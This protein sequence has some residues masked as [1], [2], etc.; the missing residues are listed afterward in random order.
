MPAAPGGIESVSQSLGGAPAKGSGVRESLGES[1]E[2]V[3]EIVGESAPADVTTGGDAGAAPGKGG[4][5][6]LFSDSV[7]GVLGRRKVEEVVVIPPVEEQIAQITSEL[8]RQIEKLQIKVK[9]V[10]GRGEYKAH[11]I[12][13]LYRQI[14]HYRQLITEAVHMAKEAL[15]GLYRQYVLREKPSGKN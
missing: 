10:R 3:G 9:R 7:A 8:T 14:R 13:D 4:I 1:A 6:G 5:L 11:Q 12:E 2:R 15:E